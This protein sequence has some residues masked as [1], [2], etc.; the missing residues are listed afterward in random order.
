MT[1]LCQLMS[2][3]FISI[4]I[5]EYFF[6]L[7]SCNFKLETMFFVTFLFV[8]LLVKWFKNEEPEPQLEVELKTDDILLEYVYERGVVKIILS[9]LK[10]PF[11]K[12]VADISKLIYIVLPD[13]PVSQYSMRVEPE[14]LLI[15]KHKA[16]SNA[17]IVIQYDRTY[18]P[19]KLVHSY[20]AMKYAGN[21]VLS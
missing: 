1:M 16:F 14:P 12:C 4:N 10:T 7:I 21:G 15:N 3:H 17:T 19:H 5:N 11:D 18:H 9:Y 20:T 6:N 8:W 13:I 2:T